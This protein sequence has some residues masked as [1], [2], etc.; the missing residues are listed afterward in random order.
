MKVCP[1]CHNRYPEEYN[2]C[3]HDGTILEMEKKEEPA[4]PVVTP[5][6]TP[7]SIP[8]PTPANPVPLPAS[9]KPAIPG[10]KSTFDGKL[11]QLIGWSI[12]GAVV[13]AVTFGIMFPFALCW[14]KSWRYKHMIVDGYRLHFDG[15]GGQ[16]IGK[17]ILW[18]LLSIVTFGIYA[19]FIPMKL[20]KWELSHVSMSPDR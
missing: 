11:I 13:T 3:P 17:W 6:P 18:M 4:A 7:S 15:N 14:K 16:L 10:G 5:I 8:L 19:W 1:K 12:L 9:L 20:I 2:R